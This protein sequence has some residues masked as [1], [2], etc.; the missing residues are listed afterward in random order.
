M[1]RLLGEPPVIDEEYVPQRRINQRHVDD[2]KAP[3]EYYD[4]ARF[5]ATWKECRARR[6]H[7][8]SSATQNGVSLW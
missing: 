7:I 5:Q 6:L 1:R 4:A 8:Q 3:Q 2:R